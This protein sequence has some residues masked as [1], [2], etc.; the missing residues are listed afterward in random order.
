MTAHYIVSFAVIVHSLY[1]KVTWMEKVGDNV[2]KIMTWTHNLQQVF[3]NTEM[4]VGI[5]TFKCLRSNNNYKIQ[6]TY[7][8]FHEIA[9]ITPKQNLNVYTIADTKHLIQLCHFDY[10]CVVWFWEGNIPDTL[11]V[12]ITN[13]V[14]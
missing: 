6:P 2:T 3:C 4:Y 5:Q 11:E 8:T 14:L 1:Y 12:L 9:T 13:N 10:V 7:N